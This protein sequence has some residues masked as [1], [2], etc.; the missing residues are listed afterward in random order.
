M[1]NTPCIVRE[2]ATVYTL[3][4]SATSEDRKN[5][6]SLFEAVGECHQ[7]PEALIDAVTA[8]S[9]SGPAYMYMIIGKSEEK[10]TI[11]RDDDRAVISSCL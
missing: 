11:F 8:M 2:G 4:H 7:V 1:P 3:G 9:G 6:Q 10:K 5:V